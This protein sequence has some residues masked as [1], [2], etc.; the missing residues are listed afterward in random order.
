MQEFEK[1][2]SKGMQQVT[3]YL[4]GGNIL[5]SSCPAFVQAG[6]Y[7]MC[8]YVFRNLRSR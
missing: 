8:M 1:Q 7:G 3:E 5:G 6:V 2:V 4:W